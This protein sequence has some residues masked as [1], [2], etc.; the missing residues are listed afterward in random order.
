MGFITSLVLY[1]VLS[2]TPANNNI[3]EG[4]FYVSTQSVEPRL[5]LLI[6][7]PV[8]PKDPEGRYAGYSTLELK[9]EKKELTYEFHHEKFIFTVFPNL[10]K[11]VFVTKDGGANVL[12]MRMKTPLEISSK[13]GFENTE[14][15]TIP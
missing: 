12:A 4:T 3:W 13:L 6:Y 7:H 9:G 14:F 11:T 2:I 10:P 15:V 5:I 1:T 8:D